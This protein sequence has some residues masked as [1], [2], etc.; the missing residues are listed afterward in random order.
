MFVPFSTSQ[1]VGIFFPW[2]VLI[3]ILAQIWY[4]ALSDV[5]ADVKIL[6]LAVMY[7]LLIFSV[8]QSQ[9]KHHVNLAGVIS[10]MAASAVT[11]APKTRRLLS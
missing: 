4:R 1:F 10:I 2:G 11:C 8:F 5:R 3:G 7:F 6:L 9:A